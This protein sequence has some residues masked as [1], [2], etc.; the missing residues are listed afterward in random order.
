MISDQLLTKA[1]TAQKR[2][3]S[4]TAEPI[5]STIGKYG[6]VCTCDLSEFSTASNFACVSGYL[7]APPVDR[8]SVQRSAFFV[9]SALCS[10]ISTCSA[11]NPL[12][13]NACSINCLRRSSSYLTGC[14]SCFTVCFA[15]PSIVSSL[16]FDTVDER[17][18]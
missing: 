5:L 18:S 2:V 6:K 1:T 17:A 12:A 7:P 13:F 16:N 11:T 8:V 9:P 4:A 15:A 14:S 3:S 10:L